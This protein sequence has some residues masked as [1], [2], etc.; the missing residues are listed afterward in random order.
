VGRERGFGFGFGR[1]VDRAQ[2]RVHIFRFTPWVYQL[3]MLG[4]WGC[5]QGAHP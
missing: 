1:E 3:S 5:L 2:R 4:V